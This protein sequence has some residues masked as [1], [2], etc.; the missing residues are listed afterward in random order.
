MVSLQ[1]ESDNDEPEWRKYF[2]TWIQFTT[3]RES[4]WNLTKSNRISVLKL[5]RLESRVLFHFLFPSSSRYQQKTHQSCWHCESLL[6]NVALVRIGRLH[7][8]TTVGTVPRSGEFHLLLRMRFNVTGVRALRREVHVALF[9]F[10][11]L[12]LLLSTLAGRRAVTVLV[13]RLLVLVGC[14]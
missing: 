1:C 3:K 13:L 4:A 12:S 7:L 9:T 2:V 14:Q 11:R 6:A 8:L 5:F 10:E